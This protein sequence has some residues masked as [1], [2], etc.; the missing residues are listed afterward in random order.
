M[1][2]KLEGF[3]LSR[4]ALSVGGF[5]VVSMIAFL[6]AGPY[7]A[8]LRQG[9]TRA[10]RVLFLGA[11]GAGLLAA[12]RQADA[13]AA[14]GAGAGRIGASAAD[15]RERAERLDR[16]AAVLDGTGAVPHAARP[17]AYAA[18][19]ARGS[20]A[21]YLD[22]LASSTAGGAAPAH[23]AALGAAFGDAER[24]LLRLVS[25][26]AALEGELDRAGSRRA[27]MAGSAALLILLAAAGG[28]ALALLHRERRLREARELAGKR[29]EQLAGTDSMTGLPNEIQFQDRVTGAIASGGATSVIVLDLDGFGL[30]NDR[31]G[32]AFGDVVIKEIAQRLRG[33]ADD[34]SGF[35]ARIGGDRFG[36]CVPIDETAALGQFCQRLIEICALPVSKGG[37]AEV[38]SV[39]VGAVAVACAE[40]DV[41][42][43]YD[44]L[45]R[46]ARFALS[47][48]KV[49]GYE[50]FTIYNRTLREK[51][52]D[53][54]AMMAD[55]PAALRAGELEV[56][57]QP[58][59]SLASGAVLGFEALVRWF[60]G[61]ISVPPSDLV[62]I[63]E[64]R[65]LVLDL[66]RYMVERA[67]AIVGD[68]NRRRKTAYS[69][70]VN[71][72]AAHLQID[73][74]AELISRCISASR[75]APEL[76]T[77]EITETV[78]LEERAH[79]AQALARLRRTGCRISIDD[80]GSGYSSLAYL[81]NISADELKID[82]TLTRDIETSSQGRRILET[83]LA[84]AEHLGVDVVVEG[85]E[86]EGQAAVLLGF[87]CS[88]AQGYLFGRPRPAAEWLA[89]VT[90]GTSDAA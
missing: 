9:F 63:A 25:E 57:L 40:R 6:V 58:K 20:V 4:A 74:G 12:L 1:L 76:L 85:I 3:L 44:V 13:L 5:C 42:S 38:T 35:A 68:W 33:A 73:G 72:S 28:A 8:D 29:L 19:S 71:L 86:S 46:N 43:D 22:L 77:V 67:T 66:D 15:L 36:I 37:E 21:A 24:G 78:E 27:R 90:Y 87:G 7:L 48:S 69:V 61:G 32:R 14:N 64:Q 30:I 11:D 84:L 17:V 62:R 54:V 53:R 65:G 55:L 52:V 49:L 81:R 39:S 75:L 18:G 83:V 26:T 50:H 79:V 60:R 59:V 34:A 70:S 88:V 82:R 41:M 2:Q 80:F 51:H 23:T 45:L 16:L 89:D 47:A 56:Y 31:C 10:E